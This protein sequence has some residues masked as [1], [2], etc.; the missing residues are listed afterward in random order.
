VPR[1]LGQVSYGTY[2]WHWPVILVLHKVMDTAPVVTAAFAAALATGLAALSAQLVETPVRRA[3]ALEHRRW[4]V[5]AAGLSLSLVAALVVLPAVLASTRRPDLVSARTSEPMFAD[6]VPW[7]RQ[8][9]PQG[10]DLA[11]AAADVPDQVRP[12][13]PARPTACQVVRGSGERWLLVGD[14]QAQMTLDAFTALARDHHL[15]LFSGIAR[16]CPW[17][18]GL[19]N[20]GQP[21]E[22]A[23]VC[24]A[25][26]GTFYRTVLPRLRPDRIVVVTLSRSDDRWRRVLSDSD[27]PSRRSLEE[28]QRTA[29]ERT[30]R[31]FR[32]TGARVTFVHS[33][34]GTNGYE[35]SGPDPLACLAG[36][37]TL[38]ECAVLLPEERPFVDGFYDR[39]ARRPG[40]DVADLTPVICPDGPLCRPVLDGAI[41]WKDPDHVTA[42]VLTARRALIWRALRRAR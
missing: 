34:V 29:G 5:I 31:L 19:R 9:V 41:V 22:D 23:A 37:R 1:Y 27:R 11:A 2:L 39:W 3:P 24:R 42:T 20:L 13:T 21:A 40:V 18:Q 17:Q 36:A 32:A 12:C 28:L 4:P 6:Q 16:G 8:P 10:L 35:R 15:T 26:R 25:A 38:G 7:V 30:L 14:S 33:L